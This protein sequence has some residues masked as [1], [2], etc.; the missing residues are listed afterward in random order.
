MPAPVSPAPRLGGVGMETTFSLW[1]AMDAVSFDQ[2]LPANT[3]HIC[4][5]PFQ[6]EGTLL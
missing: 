1:L 6:K 2:K 4:H 5:H 3:T